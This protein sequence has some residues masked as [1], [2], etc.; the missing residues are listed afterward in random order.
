MEDLKDIIKLNL[1]SSISLFDITEE[2]LILFKEENYVNKSNFYFWLLT[3]LDDLDNSD[4]F[5]ELSHGHYLASYFLLVIFMPLN[6]EKLAFNHCKKAIKFDESNLKYKEW[7][8]IFS[9]YNLLSEGE[10]MALFEEISS[11][12][13]NSSILN[14]I[15][16]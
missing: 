6:Y 12:N 16:N 10:T 11:K 13:P 4:N 14:N 5:S 15:I 9:T 8:L 7:L 2:N 1:S 3:M